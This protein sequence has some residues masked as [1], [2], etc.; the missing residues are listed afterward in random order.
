ML[1][2]VLRTW[3]KCV[4]HFNLAAVTVK[5]NSHTSLLA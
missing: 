1:L 3:W 2:K 4:R 5:S